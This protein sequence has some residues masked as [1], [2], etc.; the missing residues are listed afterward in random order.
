MAVA[1]PAA[2]KATFAAIRMPAHGHVFY[3]YHAYGGGFADGG[4]TVYY[5]FRKVQR[6]AQCT[7]IYI[8]IYIYIYIVYTACK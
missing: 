7:A 5:V 8:Y 6:G 1:A 3:V 2:V 4:C